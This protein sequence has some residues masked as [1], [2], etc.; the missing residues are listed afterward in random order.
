MTNVEMIFREYQNCCLF[1]IDVG[2]R[3]I[4]AKNSKALVI[5]T[6]V[7]FAKTV[8]MTYCLNNK[9]KTVCRFRSKQCST[10]K[11]AG[12]RHHKTVLC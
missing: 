5:G 7:F 4:L 8:L 12:N 9:R 11:I 10:V 2:K 1:A 3:S 6:D